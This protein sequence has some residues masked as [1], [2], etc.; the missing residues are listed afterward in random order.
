M[1]RYLVNFAEESAGNVARGQSSVPIHGDTPENAAGILNAGG[2]LERLSFDNQPA[3]FRTFA[4]N[5]RR[6]TAMWFQEGPSSGLLDDIA[7]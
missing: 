7:R 6:G 2:F 1:P 4:R 3:V 5:S